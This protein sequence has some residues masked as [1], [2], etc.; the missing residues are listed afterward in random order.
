MEKSAAG[1]MTP[2]TVAKHKTK[3]RIASAAKRRKKK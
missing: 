1:R 3:R 2:A